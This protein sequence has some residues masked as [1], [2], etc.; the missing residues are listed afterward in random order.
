[1]RVRTRPRTSP[2]RYADEDDGDAG[3]RSGRPLAARAAG[4]IG[5]RTRTGG[6]SRGEQALRPAR[7]DRAR[8]AGLP[9]RA[10]RSYPGAD[11]GTPGMSARN[12]ATVTLVEPVSPLPALAPTPPLLDAESR[13][14]LQSLRANDATGE[15]A[16][17]RL[18]ALL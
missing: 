9:A 11:R 17:A 14:W 12:G 18:H 8:R 13:E 5:L 10:R 1:M 7:A 3:A 16:T 4:G 6:Q 2:T 15:D